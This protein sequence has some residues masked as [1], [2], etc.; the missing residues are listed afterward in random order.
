MVYLNFVHKMKEYLKIG[1]AYVTTAVAL[2]DSQKTGN[3]KETS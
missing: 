3:R 2:K 1:I